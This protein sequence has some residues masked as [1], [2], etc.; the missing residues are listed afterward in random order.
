MKRSKQISDY[1]SFA[2]GMESDSQKNK[3]YPG[4]MGPKEMFDPDLHGLEG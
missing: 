1:P 3:N 2:L 4:G